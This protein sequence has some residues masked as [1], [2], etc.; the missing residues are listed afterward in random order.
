MVKVTGGGRSIAAIVGHLRYIS[1]S[2]RLPFE[3]DRGVNREGK[4]ALHDLAEQ[5]VAAGRS[6]MRQAT[7]TAKSGEGFDKDQAMSRASDPHPL[8]PTQAG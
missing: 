7:D 8:V 6:S 1:K 2:G 3:D 5:G 4:E